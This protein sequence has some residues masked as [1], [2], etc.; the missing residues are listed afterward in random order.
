MW[1]VWSYKA[2]LMLQ[3][4]LWLYSTQPFTGQHPGHHCTT[5]WCRQR[6]RDYCWR[7]QKWTFGSFRHQ[8]YVIC[9]FYLFRRYLT[10]ELTWYMPIFHKALKDDIAFCFGYLIVPLLMWSVEQGNHSYHLFSYMTQSF[11]GDWIRVLPHSTMY[12][13]H[14]MCWYHFV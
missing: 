2:M 12:L 6:S 1:N 3:T 13:K 9:L 7:I 5:D 4:N 11:S 10:R 14:T 8:R